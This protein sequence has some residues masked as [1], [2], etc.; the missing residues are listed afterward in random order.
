MTFEVIEERL[1]VYWG[2]FLINSDDSGLEPDELQPI[3]KRLVH[4]TSPRMP[5]L[6]LPKTKVRPTVPIKRSLRKTRHLKFHLH[7]TSIHSP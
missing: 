1:P 2:S 6:Q 4:N 7:L 3:Q 5:T